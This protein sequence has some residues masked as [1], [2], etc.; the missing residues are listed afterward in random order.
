[1]SKSEKSPV[2]ACRR[3][4]WLSL[5]L[6]AMACD[7]QL[8]DCDSSAA[9]ELVYSQDGLVATKGQALMHDSCGRGA[10][11]HSAAAEGGDRRGAPTDLNFDMLPSPAGWPRVVVHRAEV[12]EQVKEG[13][14]PPANAGDVVSDSGW[15]FDAK[16]SADALALPGLSS[17]EG[18]GALRNWLA[19]GA[20]LV[21]ETQVPVWAQSAPCKSGDEEFD[22]L[23]AEVLRPY[24][25]KVC[26]NTSAAG[27]LN[28]V[29]ACTAYEALRA[30]GNCGVRLQ[31]GDVSSPVLTQ[32][33]SR[34]PRCGKP[35]PPDAQ[36][37]SDAIARVR[38]YIEALESDSESD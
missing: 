24:C 19:C 37:A 6:S 38:D 10:H 13:H 5:A 21:S 32:L 28:M 16:R 29:D 2:Q 1:M 14:M 27:G 9:E 36:L 35:M 33:E 3:G 23:Y 22:A 11:C 18:K 31:P 8:G 25:A 7:D 17:R 12:W 20:P 26:H 4:V 15:V 30:E 34:T